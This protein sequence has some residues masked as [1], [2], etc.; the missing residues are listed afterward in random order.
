MIDIKD[1]PLLMGGTITYDKPCSFKVNLTQK[2]VDLINSWGNKKN[3]TSVANIGYISPTD[4]VE[5]DCYKCKQTFT[6]QPGVKFRITLFDE[7]KPKGDVYCGNCNAPLSWILLGEG[8]E[9]DVESEYVVHDESGKV[10]PFTPEFIDGRIEQAVLQYE[11]ANHILERFKFDINHWI[12]QGKTI[13]HEINKG[14]VYANLNKKTLLNTLRIFG[15]CDLQYN[16]ENF[17]FLQEI[18]KSRG[19]SELSYKLN[20]NL[21]EY[22]S[23]LVKWK[24]S[25]LKTAGEKSSNILKKAKEESDR[26]LTEAEKKN[27]EI[28]KD[29]DAVHSLL[30]EKIVEK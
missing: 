10:I 13:N 7:L 16:I 12:G 20:E 6:E 26:I 25:S 4:I 8:E 9:G 11:T 28:L 23:R 18:L 24:D 21:T 3:W 27:Y 5:Y 1:N 30:E 19:D 29:I 22:E 2:Q 15:G 17:E 14:D